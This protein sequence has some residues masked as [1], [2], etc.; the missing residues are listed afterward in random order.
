MSVFGD[1]EP[2]PSAV[3]QGPVE[4][5]STLNVVLG[6]ER[7]QDLLADRIEEI[8]DPGSPYYHDFRSVSEIAEEFGA[9][10][11]V[12]DSVQEY[13]HQQ[14]ISLEADI[15][16]GFIFGQATVG[17]LNRL[18]STELYF[19]KINKDTFI[20]PLTPPTLPSELRGLVTEVLGLSTEPS[21]WEVPGPDS[22][23]A[24]A[25]DT[26]AEIETPGSPTVTGTREG[27]EDAL[28]RKGF[29]P[30]QFRT[31]YGIDDLHQQGY[32]GEGITMALVEG[33][34]F[35]QSSIDTF[36]S[37]FG[38]SD[39]V[40]PNV[41]QLGSGTLKRSGEPFLDIETIMIVAPA[42]SG[43]YVFQTDLQSLA[44]WVVLF[45]SPLNP[46][47]TGGVPVQILSASLGN[48]EIKWGYTPIHMLEYVFM[49]AAAS[50]VHTFISAGD[51]G[52]S[53]C[54][55]HDKTTKTRSVEYPASSQFVT[56]V[57]GTNLALHED[58]TIKGEGV[59]NDKDFPPPYNKK[60]GAGDG[61]KSKFLKRPS[62]QIGTK[63]PSAMR[64]T[65]DVAF[66]ADPNPGYVINDS[67][68]GWF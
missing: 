52:S 54:Y 5:E 46:G 15:T 50:G 34:R 24:V 7:S 41:V 68:K 53:T 43:L 62:W 14:G 55:H 30:N 49:S 64:T 42:L 65:P 13:L 1:D 3:A 23:E 40:L 47:N 39:P 6:L 31:A 29:T 45:A 9:D 16:G 20:A 56:G 37:C 4:G 25:V 26:R 17:Q 48:C 44:D 51:S 61:G 11:S 8:H 19:Y 67:K 60:P 12:I 18:F 63:I 57:G 58:N 59:W 22:S 32:H 2:D 33:S 38:I 27:C 10:D 28:K 35:D 66:F 21:L 36:T